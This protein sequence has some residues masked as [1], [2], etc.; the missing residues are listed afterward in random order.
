MKRNVKGEIER[1]K[2]RLV[3]KSYNQK[4]GT[5]YDEIFAP[6]ARRETIILLFL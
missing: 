3:A 6:V 2:V 4:A 1:H 5:N